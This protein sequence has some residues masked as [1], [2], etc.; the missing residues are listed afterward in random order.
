MQ[1]LSRR[2]RE[3]QTREAEI[4]MAA[5][6]IFY[7][8]GYDD[9][10]MDEIAKEAEFT[11]KTLYQYFVNKEDLYFAV[12]CKGYQ[13]VFD[14]LLAAEKQENSG[15]EQMRRFIF[16]YYQFYLA[17]PHT[18][19]LLKFCPFIKKDGEENA[20]CRKTEE[21]KASM[22]QLLVETIE[23]GKKDGSIRKD[24]D[25]KLSAYSMIYFTIG[26]FYR[27]SEIGPSFHNDLVLIQEEFIRFALELLS[28]TL[29]PVK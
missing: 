3:R 2:Q 20:H 16:A 18:F 8:K 26:F 14:Y 6:K 5:E 19:R 13:T 15:F 24:L 23:K 21:I 1:K 11:K 9:A 4:I 12:A 27:L 17:F 7:Q 25:S 10:S 29:A 22:V 28:N